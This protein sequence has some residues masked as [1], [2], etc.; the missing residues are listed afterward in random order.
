M[1]SFSTS[2]ATSGSHGD[3]AEANEPDID[4]SNPE[5]FTPFPRL[6]AELRIMIWQ[7]AMEEEKHLVHLHARGCKPCRRAKRRGCPRKIG[8]KLRIQ[9]VLYEQVPAWFFIDHECSYVALR[10]YSIRFSVTQNFRQTLDEDFERRS[11]NI[12]MSPTDVLVSWYSKELEW[13]DSNYFDLQFGPQARLVSNL[14]VCPWIC[15]PFGFIKRFQFHRTVETLVGKLG[16]IDALERLFFFDEKPSSQRKFKGSYHE[17]TYS[18]SI[19]K[20]FYAY[21]PYINSQFIEHIV[22][23]RPEKRLQFL[24]LDT[25]TE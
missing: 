6:P 19:M 23:R 12:I 9:G 25:E 14:T 22:A 13:E 18:K 2:I 24:I 17:S 1:A 21:L 8:P 7:F 5:Q 11:T 3:T 16:N 10:R 15:N 20:S 4:L